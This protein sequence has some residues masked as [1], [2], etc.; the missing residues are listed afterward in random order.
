[1]FTIFGNFSVARHFHTRPA[2]RR[3]YLDVAD[4]V[5]ESYRLAPSTEYGN[6]GLDDYG[7]VAFLWGSAQL[8]GAAGPDLGGPDDGGRCR[9]RRR[10][11]R[12]R[13]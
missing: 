5:I 8:T 4:N 7:Y 12:P 2:A 6:S 11:R 9:C 10:R 3:R 13:P 1:V